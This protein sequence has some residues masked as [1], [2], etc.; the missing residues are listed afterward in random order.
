MLVDQARFMQDEIDQVLVGRR[1]HR[2]LRHIDKVRN[3]DQAGNWL[4]ICHSVVPLVTAVASGTSDASYRRWILTHWLAST[5]KPSWARSYI[6]RSS[7]PT[8]EVGALISRL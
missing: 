5:C 6:S 2:S 8:T 3:L 1:R 7:W 4:R